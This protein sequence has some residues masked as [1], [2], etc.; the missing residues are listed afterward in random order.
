MGFMDTSG[1]N[2]AVLRMGDVC[3]RLAVSDETIKNYLDS[4]RLEGFK[5]PGGHWRIY[6]DSVDA[7]MNGAG[8]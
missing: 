4:G 7:L 1:D 6:S 3:E 8:E 5:L 2:R